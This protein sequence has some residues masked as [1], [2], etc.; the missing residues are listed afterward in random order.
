MKILNASLNLCSEQNS[1]K[2]ILAVIPLLLKS[3]I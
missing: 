3:F 1:I 2:Q